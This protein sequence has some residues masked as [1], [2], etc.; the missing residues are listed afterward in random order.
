MYERMIDIEM[1]IARAKGSTREMEFI[2]FFEG[3]GD[4][5]AETM[6]TWHQMFNYAKR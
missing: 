4:P 6:G 1:N 5:Q 2:S 3:K